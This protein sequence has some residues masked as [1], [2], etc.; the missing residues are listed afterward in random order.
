MKNGNCLIFLNW[1]P[2]PAQETIL[3]LSSLSFDCWDILGKKGAGEMLKIMIFFFS[4]FN[5]PQNT[6]TC[7]VAQLSN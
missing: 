2:Y 7:Q 5:F 3:L 4:F 6:K 1:M